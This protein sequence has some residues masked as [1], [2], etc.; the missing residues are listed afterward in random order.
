MPCRCTP[1][2]T[3]LR[4]ELVPLNRRYPL[5]ML[6]QACAGV[7]GRAPGGGSR[8]SGPA[9][10]GVNDR[11]S[12]ASRARRAGSAARGSRQPHP[13]QPDSGRSVARPCRVDRVPGRSRS[14]R[15]L[16]DAGVNTTIRQNRGRAIAAAC[17]QLA[18]GGEPVGR[19]A[20][21]WLSRA[22]DPPSRDRAP[23][24]ARLQRWRMNP[25][26]DPA[27]LG[28]EARDQGDRGRRSSSSS[29]GPAQ[30]VAATGLPFFDH[31]LAQLGRHGGLDLDVKARGDLEVD[32]HHT[33]E[34]TGIVLGE[35][36]ARG[37]RARRRAS[38]ASPRSRCRSTRRSSRS[39]S[40][41]PAGPY[42]HYD[43]DL[44]ETG[45]ARQ[46][47]LRASS[48]LRSSGAPSPTRRRSPC[49]SSFVEGATPTTSSR[50]A[51]RRSVAR[52]AT[53]CG[54][55][56][57]ASPRPRASC[58]RYVIA[59]LDYGIGNLRSA[60]KALQHVGADARLVDSPEAASAPSGV[61]LPGV[62]AFGAC[63]RALRALGARRGR[64][65]LRRR[66]TSFPR[67]LRRSAAALRKLGGGSRSTPGSA[68]CRG[69]VRAI[70]GERAPTRRCSG[71][72]SANRPDRRS[73]LLGETG[74]PVVLLRALL[75]A[76]LPRAPTRSGAS[77]GPATTAASS[78]WRSS[79]ATCSAPSSTRRSRPPP[80]C[81]VL[82]RF[83]RICDDPSSGT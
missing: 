6:M 69:T 10:Q 59:V 11:P 49:T 37:A 24:R 25:A 51:S 54:S 23:R 34:D 45:A 2:T 71:T 38:A 64:A 4:D 27:S 48:S 80:A 67:D 9:S 61:V 76:R 72:S 68:S 43:V 83:A 73:R 82:D 78:P 22:G 30:S 26:T 74:E 16:R 1:P 60:E 5:A 35:A 53:P 31:M 52:C 39:P 65:A 33:V 7:P 18:A 17:G 57:A 81:S 8:S 36:F 55:R 21:A 44:G 14:R 42:L 79:V 19:P 47:A 32:A 20:G 3:R 13:A 62:G 29:T 77:S 40:T 12:D 46:P 50:R 70:A 63:A 56:G 15:W 75:R 28:A 66:R 41:C 58:R